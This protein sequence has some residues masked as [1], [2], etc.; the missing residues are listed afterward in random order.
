MKQPTALHALGA[1]EMAAAVRRRDVSP[2]ELV[3]AHIARIEA[4]DG[5]V[6]ALVYRDFE[7]ARA[8]ARAA[9]QAIAR[10]E[11]S[12]PL[13][14]VPFTVKECIEAEGVPLCCG[15]RLIEPFTPERDAGV[16]ARLRGAGAILLGATNISE[17]ASFPDTVNLVYGP[18]RN[19]HDAA[20]SVSG[21]SGGEAAA[22][23]TGMSPLGVGSDYAGSIRGPAHATGIVGLRTGR[24][25]VPVDGFAPARQP[26]GRMLWSTIGPLARTV[27][28]LE[29]ALA[30]MGRASSLT[31]APP[32]RRVTVLA[33]G[34]GRRVGADSQRAVARAADALAR[35]G[36]EVDEDRPPLQA[37]VERMFA[38]VTATETR[39]VL[40]VWLPDRLADASPQVAAQWEAVRDLRPDVE[41]YVARLSERPVLE[42]EADAWLDEHPIL[43]APVAA[44][45]AGLLGALDVRVDGEAVDL[46][47]AYAPCAWPSALGLPVATVP[48]AR[49]ADGLP[50]GVQ[51]VGRRGREDEVLAVA[52]VLEEALGGSSAPA[53]DD[54]P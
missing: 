32:P 24:G 47:E 12:G 20:R 38:D 45:P 14:G 18:T 42:R 48:A 21:S 4:V 34:L 36:H 51:V 2:V 19:P 35:A 29:V 27:D 54:V 15:S 26:P 22:V 49:A 30:V 44:A 39:L 1:A 10:G 52:R 53:S 13:H 7:R 25:T 41:Q 8:A 3:D 50:V 16:V 33:D 23:A 37:A 11:E 9:E 6:G 43:L 46:F 31:P 17:L 40:G 28:D 5:A